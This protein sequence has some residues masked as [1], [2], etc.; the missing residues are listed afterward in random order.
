MLLMH[1]LQQ[2]T[3]GF[4]KL[5]VVLQVLLKWA[6]LGRNSSDCSLSASLALS[7]EIFM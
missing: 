7:P 1:A 4:V 3:V 2:Q 5:N 6:H